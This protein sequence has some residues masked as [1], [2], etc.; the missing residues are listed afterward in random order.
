M[1]LCNV[2][3]LG[4]PRVA[5]RDLSRSKVRLLPPFW[6]GSRVAST[7]DLWG[8]LQDSYKV[9]R[10]ERAAEERESLVSVEL[11]TMR[12]P[13]LRPSKILCI[14]LNYR[15][16]AAETGMAIPHV[17]VIFNKFPTALASDG[18]PIMIPVAAQQMDYEAELVIVVGD[19]ADNI[20]VGESG[21]Y[22]AGY[23]VGN[24]VSARDLQMR[25]SQWLLGKSSKGFAPLGSYLVTSDE[26][27][28]PNN[29]PIRLW[30]NGTLC[31]ESNTADMIFNVSEII[32]YLS[33]IWTLEPG[34]VIFTGTPEGV[35]LGQ[36]EAE[37]KWLQAGDVVRVEI[38]GLGELTN[39][40]V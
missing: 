7:D 6:E 21:R 1:Q 28:D 25:T 35:I 30:R 3:Y 18:E 40:F 29:L 37:R 8:V 5:F 19:R 2:W 34:D 20:E 11:V 14:G 4:E 15:R 17:P 26:V 10:L 33:T 9:S 39:H 23:A 32:A 12:P 36:P 13:V 24:D 16:H 27:P 22:I 31:Q 38:E